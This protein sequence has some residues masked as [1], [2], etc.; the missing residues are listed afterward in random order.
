MVALGNDG[1]VGGGGNDVLIG[2]AGNDVLKGNSGGIFLSVEQ[3]K[4]P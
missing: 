3:T 2:Q 4:M 1:L